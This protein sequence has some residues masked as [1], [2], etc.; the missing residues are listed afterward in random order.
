MKRRKKP[1]VKGAR[2]KLRAANI[3]CSMSRRS[4]RKLGKGKQEGWEV[5]GGRIELDRSRH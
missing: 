3:P 1:R 4:W 2:V 5:P